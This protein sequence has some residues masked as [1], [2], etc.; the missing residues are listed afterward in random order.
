MRTMQNVHVQHTQQLFMFAPSTMGGSS[1]PPR[2]PLSTGLVYHY[3]SSCTTILFSSPQYCVE[4]LVRIII[5]DKKKAHL[6]PGIKI[7]DQDR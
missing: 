7:F 3:N 2:T 1:E 5:K 4:Q 6:L